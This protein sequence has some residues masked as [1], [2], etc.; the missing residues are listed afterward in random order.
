VVHGAA[1]LSHFIQRR[2]LM[3]YEQRMARAAYAYGVD[4]RRSQWL[5]ESSIGEPI[6]RSVDRRW[7]RL[8][9]GLSTESLQSSDHAAPL[10]IM[11]E[12]LSLAKLLRAPL[13]SLRLLSDQARLGEPWPPALPLGTTRGSIQWI[14][15]DADALLELPDAERAFVLGSALG[16]LQCDHGPLFA[17]HLLAHRA[18]RGLGLVRLLLGPW[19]RVAVFSADRA[20]LL[21]AGRLDAALSAVRKLAGKQPDWMP[22][23]PEPALREQALRD[24]DRSG[25]MTRMRELQNHQPDGDDADATRTAPN[26]AEPVHASDTK[27]PSAASPAIAWSLARCDERL[28]RRLG[29]L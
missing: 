3:A 2:E 28:T 19:S 1:D 25:V 9:A 10:P 24:F 14:V 15:L 18:R 23:F 8:I 5:D 13:P 12:L 4:L 6:M 16:H 17:A 11:Q 20:G 27:V 22:R 26:S 7:N 21:A 29:L